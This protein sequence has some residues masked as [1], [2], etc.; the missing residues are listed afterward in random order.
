MGIFGTSVPKIKLAVSPSTIYTLNYAKILKDEPDNE[1]L[2]HQSVINGHKEFI[3]KGTHWSFEVGIN[4]FKESNPGT[5]YSGYAALLGK[6]FY[7]YRHSSLNV[8]IQDSSGTDVPFMLYEKQESYYQT[9]D[10]KDYLI[11]KFQSCDYVSLE[12]SLS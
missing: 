9:T 5:A 4:L 10:F 3:L 12:Q 6:K 2:V 11:L 7:L 1:Y 8:A